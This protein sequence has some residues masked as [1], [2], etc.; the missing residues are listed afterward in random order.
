MSL[1]DG[2]YLTGMKHGPTPGAVEV[3]FWNDDATL[4]AIAQAL[5]I[6]IAE[7][8]DAGLSRAE[9]IRGAV[10]RTFNPEE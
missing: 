1:P 10:G 5:E 7:H 9:L 6:D 8:Y 3:A 2:V 4:E